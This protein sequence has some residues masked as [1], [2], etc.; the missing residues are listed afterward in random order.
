VVLIRASAVLKNSLPTLK[1]PRGAGHFFIHYFPVAF[2]RRACFAVAAA[3]AASAVEAFVVVVV[4]V[5]RV[6]AL[7]A[8]AV[9]C[10]RP[11]V[12][13]GCFS[14]LDYFRGQVAAG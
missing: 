3:V 6:V 12:A 9:F 11:V 8:V 13:A 5:H 7:L 4:V 10:C 1:V 14:G 2:D